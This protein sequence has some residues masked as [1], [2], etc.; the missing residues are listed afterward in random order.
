[1]EHTS[2]CIDQAE[3]ADIRPRD[4]AERRMSRY[5]GR[6]ATGPELSRDLSAAEARDAM[7]MVLRGEVD[8]AQAAVLLI[9]LR[10]K[11]ES[12][13]EL[14]GVL[15]ALRTV[16]ERSVAA[17]P[18]VVDM[19][20]PYNGYV[21]HLPAAPFMPAM[22]AAC[23]VPA[24][25]HG[26]VESG[27]KWGVTAHRILSAAGARVD[28]DSAAAAGKLAD[29]GWAYID[30]PGFCAPLAA[31][32][33]LRTLIVKRPCLSLL[34][35]LIAPVEGSARTHMWIGYAHT[36][37]PEICERLGRHFGYA[38]MLAVRGVEGGV[39]TS[40]SGRVR[41]MRYMGDHALEPVEIAA[42]EAVGRSELRAPPLPAPAG[43]GASRP[44]DEGDRDDS[45]PLPIALLEQWADSAAQAGMAALAGQP[46]P[47]A[48]ML[49][50]GAAAMLR[51]LG[52]V[53]DLASGAAMARAAIASGEALRRFR[54]LAADPA[55]APRS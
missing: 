41:A 16:A 24:V 18:D 15:A 38:S 1:M 17:V 22:L 45:G 11:R 9:A 20:E 27:P 49:I 2:N 5:L 31:L 48:D 13:D 10:M 35:K 6:V 50:I 40:L 12:H 29:A 23:N 34:E 51:H 43:H 21:R 32:A 37:Y 8:R 42:G 33:R 39:L 46:G 25:L 53:D 52:R 55:I 47:T 19:A 44:T 14:V 26:C 3:P 54:A 4:A 28:L 30:L 7:E 36:G